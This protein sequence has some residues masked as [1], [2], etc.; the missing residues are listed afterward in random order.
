MG[1]GGTAAPDVKCL[2]ELSKNGYKVKV[3]R[4]VNLH[5]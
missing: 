2:A 5:R 3:M 1:G 4:R